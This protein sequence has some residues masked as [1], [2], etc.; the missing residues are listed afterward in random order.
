MIKRNSKPL[1]VI[2]NEYEREGAGWNSI[3]KVEYEVKVAPYYLRP[4]DLRYYDGVSYTT[5]D[6]K[7]YSP[8][9]LEAYVKA[10]SGENSEVD[11]EEGERVDFSFKIGD[12][13]E[14]GAESYKVDRE[15]KRTIHSD[16]TIH[17]AV[18]ENKDD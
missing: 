5:Q 10:I 16:F 14:Y 12:M 13:V 2:R 6:L 15:H 17:I 3:L 1:L 18:K 8:K 9:D 4:E 11:M 7:I